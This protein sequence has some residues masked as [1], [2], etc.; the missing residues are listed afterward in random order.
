MRE[1]STPHHGTGAPVGYGRCGACGHVKV[2]DERG[3]PF[4]HNRFR[5][6]RRLR[7]QRCPGEHAAATPLAPLAEA[8]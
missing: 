5:F 8:G 3:H 1:E 6:R 2:L 7:V 4:P